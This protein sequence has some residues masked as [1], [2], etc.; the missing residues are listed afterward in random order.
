[1]LSSGLYWF[2]RSTSAAAR[3]LQLGVRGTPICVADM[4]VQYQQTPVGEYS[5][6]VGVTALRRGIQVVGPVP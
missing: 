5:E 3:A 2:A 6:I 4:F 1:M